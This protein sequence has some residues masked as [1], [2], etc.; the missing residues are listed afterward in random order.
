VDGPFLFLSVEGIVDLLIN[1]GFKYLLGNN[2][3]LQEEE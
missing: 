3:N 1:E 2:Q